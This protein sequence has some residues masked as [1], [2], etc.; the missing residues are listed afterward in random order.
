MVEIIIIVVSI[1]V[2][3]LA[4]V[5]W[6]SSHKVFSFHLFFSY[7]EFGNKLAVFLCFW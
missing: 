3:L 7:L 5:E 1:Y 4:F 6:S 2:E